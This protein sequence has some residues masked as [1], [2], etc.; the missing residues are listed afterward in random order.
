V[1]VNATLEDR[2]PAIRDDGATVV[3]LLAREMGGRGV[4]GIAV[5]VLDSATDHEVEEF[6]LRGP[7]PQ[8]V[9]VHD[10]GAPAALA[11]L[12]DHWARMSTA[13][14][15]PDATGPHHVAVEG[16]P[17]VANVAAIGDTMIRYREPTVDLRVGTALVVSKR[18]SAWSAAPRA[19]TCATPWGSIDGAWI[20]LSRRTALLRIA[21]HGP[22]SDLC[23]LPDPAMHVLHWE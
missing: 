18:V 9:K 19:K 7:A 21:Y 12:A 13:E 23:W 22:N 20:D 17:T 14:L 10:G 4:D 8:G 6:L 15:K 1:D 16:E 3:A 2:L 11:S 5:V